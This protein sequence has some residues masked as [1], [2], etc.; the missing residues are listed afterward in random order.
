MGHALHIQFSDLSQAALISEL[1]DDPVPDGE[2]PRSVLTANLDHVVQLRRNAAFRAAY[3]KA[4]R[5]TADGMPV[6]LYAKLRGAV[7]HRLT[8]ADLFPTL[9][10]ALTP[11]QHRCFFVASSRATALALTRLLRPRGFTASSLRFEIPPRGFEADPDY[12]A[13]LAQ[14]IR[15]H[16]TTHLFFGVG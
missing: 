16:G 8:G 11:D 14:R 3:H 1:T 5:V 7:S 6:F 9:L 15:E 4:W 12:S 2:G 13:Q 10:T